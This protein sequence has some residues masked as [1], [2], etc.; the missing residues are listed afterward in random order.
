MMRRTHNDN[1]QE[2][3]GM[4]DELWGCLECGEIVT[5]SHFCSPECEWKYGSRFLYRRFNRWWCSLYPYRLWSALC[6]FASIVWR[7]YE[8]EISEWRIDWRTAW[9]VSRRIWEV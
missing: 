9:Q 2:G 6:L 4:M 8:P 1:L 7:K 5:D 3:G